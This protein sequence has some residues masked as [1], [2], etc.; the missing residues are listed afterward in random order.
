M[1]KIAVVLSGCG[2]LD[3]AEIQE[4]VLTLLMIERYGAS[5]QCF[6]PDSD[7]HHVSN[8]LTQ[9]E[10]PEKRNVLVEA[11]RI[12]RGE[13]KTLHDLNPNEFDALVF[14]GG[15]GAALNLSDFG[16]GKAEVRVLPDLLTLARAFLKA[17][18]PMGFICIAPSLLPEIVNHEPVSLTIGNDVDTAARLESLGATHV[19]A[20]MSEI[21]TDKKHKV[22][23]TPAYMLEGT[24]SQ[25]AEGIEKCVAAVVAMMV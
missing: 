20:G 4:A 8:H 2:Y 3:G 10:M 6:A 25:V 14:P 7:Q 9:T 19:E 17:K 22:V 5:Y 21:V 18:K 13:I 24:I 15:F 16:E 1:K 12:A 23:S 11:A